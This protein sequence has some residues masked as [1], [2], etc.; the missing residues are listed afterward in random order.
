MITF[1]EC[2]DCQ[3]RFKGKAAILSYISLDSRATG[4]ADDVCPECGSSNVKKMSG[5]CGAQAEGRWYRNEC[6]CGHMKDVENEK[7]IRCRLP[8]FFGDDDGSTV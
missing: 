4:A 3:L 8:G 6:E 7:C 5:P 1:K 2:D